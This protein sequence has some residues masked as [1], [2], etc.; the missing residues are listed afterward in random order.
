VAEIE[1]EHETMNA[2]RETRNPADC[3][4]SD[5]AAKSDIWLRRKIGD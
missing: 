4:E 3:V 1:H 5:A 2:E